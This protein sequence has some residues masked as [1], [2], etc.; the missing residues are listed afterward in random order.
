MRVFDVG[1]R[2]SLAAV[3]LA[4]IC[5]VLLGVSVG[6]GR[7]AKIRPLAA[8]AVIVAFGD[9]LTAGYGAEAGQD[10]PSVLAKLSGRQVINAGVPGEVSATGAARLPAVLEEHRPAL[11][12]L[13]HGGNDILVGNSPETIVANLETMI[14]LCRAAGADVVLLAVPQKGLVLKP[15]PFYAEVAAR[16]GLPC[17][18][19]II[20]K[21]L[22]KASLKSDYIHPN[23][24]GYVQIAEAVWAELRRAQP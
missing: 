1:M 4:A 23:A 20:A 9:S 21:V 12:L 13:C 15:A 2:K 3:L 8:D 16:H 10:Y 24:A 22:G 14:R 17:E 11:V 18:K 5:T 6:C 7:Q 19:S